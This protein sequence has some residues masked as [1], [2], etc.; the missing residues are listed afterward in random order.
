[1]GYA[2]PAA[3]GVQYGRPDEA[4]WCITGDGGFQMTLEELAVVREEKLPHQD[5]RV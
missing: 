1:M 5:R 2:L 4:V 3:I